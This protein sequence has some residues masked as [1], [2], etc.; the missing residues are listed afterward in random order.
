M[1]AG[2]G[3]FDRGRHRRG[4]L[5]CGLGDLALLPGAGRGAAAGGGRARPP[6]ARLAAL[7]GPGG[8]AALRAGVGLGRLA[9]G[10]GRG[11]YPLRP[12]LH[13][14]RLA[15]GLG[16]PGAL[17]AAWH[18]RDGG[19]RRL[20][21]RLRP[22]P[23][24]ELGPQRRRPRRPTCR[25]CRRSTSARPRWASA[26]SSSPP[27]SAASSSMP[28]DGPKTRGPIG[29]FSA[30]RQRWG[31]LLVAVL[32]LC[33]D[34]LFFAVDSLPATVPVAVAL[35]PHPAATNDLIASATA[36]GR[37][38]GV[39]LKASS[40]ATR[41]LLRERL[42]VTLGVGEGE[43]LVLARPDQQRR[44]L[45]ALDQCLARRAHGRGPSP[46]PSPW[47]RRGGR[48]RRGRPGERRRRRPRASS[49]CLVSSP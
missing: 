31:A 46:R 25:V 26:T 23:G 32:A 48:P 7:V 14:P 8:G 3:A 22:P 33:F 24:P 21:R 10:R 40:I 15:A 38:S 36:S 43:D 1:G 18:L 6:P 4:Q 9:R 42:G 37:S 29:V 17:A 45:P 39:K 11:D 2:A 35:R 44:L 12:R 47:R 5:L 30:H 28:A 20:A 41:V 19:G 27:W 49:G 34:L 13:R 16:R